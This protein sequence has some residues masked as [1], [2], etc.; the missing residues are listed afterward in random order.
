MKGALKQNLFAREWRQQGPCPPE[1]SSTNRT[2]GSARGIRDWSG[3]SW[4]C[5]RFG[6]LPK[7]PAR[8]EMRR[9]AQDRPRFAGRV[10]PES[11]RR[12]R[13]P[14]LDKQQPC[15]LAVKRE[16]L[17]AV[18]GLLFWQAQRFSANR[19]V[20]ETSLAKDRHLHSSD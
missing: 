2:S 7:A 20:L 19:P 6:H 4:R 17:L 13:G 8:Y 10:A 5:P 16:K 11:R 3:K 15:G 9:D 1:Y 14:L 12:V 18:I